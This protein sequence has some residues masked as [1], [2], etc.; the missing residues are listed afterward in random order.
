MIGYV[1]FLCVFQRGEAKLLVED[2]E[3]A[4]ADMRVAAEKSPQVSVKSS[5]NKKVSSYYN[6]FSC[7][8]G[9]GLDWIGLLRYSNL[10]PIH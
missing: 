1:K 4:V 9:N 10:N 6:K 2:F 3:G 5:N 7:R 8:Y